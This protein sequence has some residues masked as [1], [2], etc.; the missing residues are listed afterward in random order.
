MKTFLKVL[1]LL[2][3]IGFTVLFNAG[4]IDIRIDEIRYLLGYIAQQEEASNT[5]GIIAKYELIKRRMLYGEDNITSYE[6]EARIQALMTGDQL[7]EKNT[8]ASKVYKIPVRLTLNTIRI[9]LG[10]K[11]INPKEDDKVFSV[12]EIAYFWERNRKYT[13]ALKIYDDVLSASNL[14]PEIAA[15][16]LVHKSFCYSMLS[17]Y[18]KSKQIYEDVINKYPATEAGILAWKLLDFIQSIE[19]E[20]EN[21][22]NAKLTELEKAR[23][24]YLLMD[25]RNAI[26]NYSMFLGK[27]TRP[28]MESEAR[29]YKGRAHEEL[30][31]TEDAIMEYRRVIKVDASKKW[32]RQANRRMLMLGEFYEQ[33]KSISEEA[34][35]QLE[36]YQDKMFMNNVE[37]YSSIVAQNTLKG[38]LLKE[39]KKGAQKIRA[40]NDSIL[41][42]IDQIGNF[43]LTGEEDV[44][45]RKLEQMRRELVDK[46]KLSSAEMQELERKQNLAENPYRRPSTLKRIFDENSSELR[47][48]YNK[49]L[50]SGVKLS[51]K[52]LVEIR[53]E[54]RGTIGG[55]RLIQSNM[56]DQSFENDVVERIKNWKFTPVPDSLGEITVNFPFEFHEEL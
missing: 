20:R 11:I 51:G 15:A 29:F 52:M 22:Q 9:M 24:F 37:K 1:L 46:G 8:W 55:V 16:I 47:Y 5:F 17:N 14:A 3:L 32:A 12:L 45:K 27:D 35:R 18:S 23:Q 26:K 7:K 31:E 49:R 36:A 33:Q 34:K 38:E 6:L 28:P 21:L 13:E 48:L 42:L 44:K 43:D 53:I 25:F 56:G 50:R 41:K 39:A 30:G 4:L 10:K 2:L 54:A 40:T 19:R